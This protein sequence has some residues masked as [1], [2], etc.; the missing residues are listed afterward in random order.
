ME[1]LI[2][3]NQLTS[4][5]SYSPTQWTDGAPPALNAENLKKIET[6]IMINRSTG[7]DIIGELNKTQANNDALQKNIN[8]VNENY[9][10]ADNEIKQTINSLTLLNLKDT[11]PKDDVVVLDGGADDN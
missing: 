5:P 1:K 3:I 9:Q 2:D 11:G 7:N 8:N 10:A 6:A 4:N